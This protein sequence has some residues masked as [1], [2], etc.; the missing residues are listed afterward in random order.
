[1][2][3]ESPSLAEFDYRP[4]VAVVLAA[5]GALVVCGVAVTFFATFIDQPV[6]AGFIQLPAKQARVVLYVLSGATIVTIISQFPLL[7]LA[8]GPPCRIAVTSGSVLMSKP[9]WW[10]TSREEIEVPFAA[11]TD[12][13]TKKVAPG[14]YSLQF[15]MN[16]KRI[17]VWNYMMRTWDEF[18]ALSKMLLAIDSFGSAGRRPGQR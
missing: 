1:M 9:T 13:S 11:I 2:A 15:R 18:D 17:V 14:C 6:E 4:R 3:A 12:V 8:L 5:C 10:G 7:M 16:G